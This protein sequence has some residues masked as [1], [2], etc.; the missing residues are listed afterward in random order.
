MKWVKCNRLNTE[1]K[2]AVRKLWNTE[3]PKSIA[4]KTPKD[5]DDYLAKLE[6]QNHILLLDENEK[7]VGWFFGFIRDSERWF[8][9]I[10]DSTFHCKGYGS[11]L[12]N[13]AKSLYA[14]LNGWV[15]TS[16]NHSRLSGEPYVSP[17]GFYTNHNFEVLEDV[18]LETEAMKTIKIKWQKT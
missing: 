15:I 9:I 8:A 13:E 1:Q 4:L 10:V 11:I 5:L 7:I 16:A 3:Y 14:E 18:T 17:L 2:H 12:L 6:D